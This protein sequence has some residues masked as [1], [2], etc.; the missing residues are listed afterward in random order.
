LHVG[1]IEAALNLLLR[2]GAVSGAGSATYQQ[3]ATGADCGTTSAADC[4]ADCRAHHGTH[5]SLGG[6]ATIG[7]VDLAADG[8]IRIVTAILLFRDKDIE[9]LVSGRH[10]RN[11]RSER[12]RG[13]TGQ[14][15]G[16]QPDHH[17]V[18][19]EHISSLIWRPIM[20]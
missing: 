11:R 8:L 6:S 7:I 10:H 1:N 19:L 13:T 9:R 2:H 12:R 20:A 18:S 15:R 16:N 5:R 3:P 4:G 14:K 17:D